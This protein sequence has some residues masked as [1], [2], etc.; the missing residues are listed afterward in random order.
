MMAPR[1]PILMADEPDVFGPENLTYQDDGSLIIETEP[2]LEAQASILGMLPWDANLADAMG[3]GDLSTIANEIIEGV[4]RDEQSR[5]EWSKTIKDSLSLL[6]FENTPRD[7]PFPGSCGVTYPMIA[8]AA[9]RFQ[10]KAIVE[11]FPEGGPVDTKIMG[12]ETEQTREQAERVRDYLNYHMTE[13]DAGYEADFDQMLFPL[14]THGSAFRKVYDDPIE[15]HV[16]SRF[17]PADDVIVSY[18]STDIARASRV[19]HKLRMTPNDV[20]KMQLAGMWSD[21]ELSPVGTEP[22]RGPMREAADDVTGNEPSQD[23][24]QARREI[25]EVHCDIDVPGDDGWPSPP[26]PDGMMGPL[27]EKPPGL[28][29]PYV[30][31]VDKETQKVLAIRRNWVDGDPLFKR[32]VY[33]VHYRYLA[34]EGFYGLGLLH[35]VGGLARGATALLRQLVDAGQMANLPGGFKAKGAKPEH[36]QA[37]I[38][39]GEWRE[40]DTMGM[41]VNQAFMPLPFKEPSPALL[42]MMRG[43]IDSGSRLAGLSDAEVGD[44]STQ[45]AVG[46]TLALLEQATQNQSAIHKRMH[47]AQRTELKLIASRIRRSIPEGGYPYNVAGG[48]RQVM[49]Q[50]FDDR[51]DIIPISDPKNFTATQRIAKAQFLLQ[52]ASGAAAL[53]DGAA[54]YRRVYQ[55][56][57]IDDADSL[58]KQPPPKPKAADP[59][60]ENLAVMQ[61]V[62]IT[63]RPD[64][65]HEAHAATHLEF[66]KL[67]NAMQQ[68]WFGPL[69]RHAI[70]HEMW[71]I[72]KAAA[73]QFG[74]RGVQLP[75]LGQ[76]MPPDTENAFAMLAP[77]ATRQVVA[78]IIAATPQIPVA[79][80]PAMVQAQTNATEVQLRDARENRKLGIDEV[81]VQIAGQQAQERAANDAGKLA[82]DRAQHAEEMEFDHTKLAIDARLEAQAL[83]QKAREAEAA[84]LADLVQKA[85]PQ[86]P[87]LGGGFR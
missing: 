67:P 9:I 14:A 16:T 49:A 77:A 64:Q 69:F 80:D 42:D 52:T 85:T 47:R 87:P 24:P 1:D 38:G 56:V 78:G 79:P 36:N 82:A 44:G 59:V 15:G 29:L 81:R 5:S 23:D 22:D 7:E 27:I 72:W 31:T 55:L 28:L 40:I 45:Q 70:E 13:I 34:G 50:D 62:G 65:D 20:K 54:V 39:F 26:G 60:S 57:G 71:A 30:V 74:G 37:P 32:D 48:N 4:E 51:V 6:G 75:P 2:L 41:P 12:E 8:E 19:T 61:G 73:A 11:M 86:V 33:F 3:E 63:V 66:L 68:P 43:M 76:E 18:G 84:R 46:T 21:I 10:S 83:T 25:Y 35:I 58:M 53:H 17:I